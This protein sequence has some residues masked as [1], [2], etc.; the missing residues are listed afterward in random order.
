MTRHH[1]HLVVNDDTFNDGFVQ[2]L[3][4][5]VLKAL[6]FG[7]LHVRGVA[8]EYVVVPLAGGAGPDVGHAVAAK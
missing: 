8:V 7:N 2:H 4:V 6:G 5:P 3:L 1:T